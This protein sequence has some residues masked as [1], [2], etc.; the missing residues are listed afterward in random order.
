MHKTNLQPRSFM[1]DLTSPLCPKYKNILSMYRSVR[2]RALIPVACLQA[3][4]RLA[5]RS[6]DSQYVCGRLRQRP[7]RT[8][9]E[10]IKL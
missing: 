4:L 1:H 6:K 7:A 2:K 3:R 5:V 9:V 10:Y 8:L